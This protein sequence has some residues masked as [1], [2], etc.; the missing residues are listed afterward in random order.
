MI[1]ID[2]TDTGAC[3]HVVNGAQEHGSEQLPFLRGK[4]CH[5]PGFVVENDPVHG[6]V[7]LVSLGQHI[8]AL[9]AAVGF[10]RP[11]LDEVLLF[12][13]GQ[14]PRNGGVAQVKGF[15]NVPGAGRLRPLCEVAHD[16]PLS[17]RQIH[18]C[19][20]VIHGCLHAAAE[21]LQ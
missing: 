3:A 21:N 17:G 16:V 4:A 11:K 19:Q 14:Q 6:F 18:G 13:P 8:D 5:H 9:A 12:Q 7:K 10:V 2:F 1:R 20:R 15:L